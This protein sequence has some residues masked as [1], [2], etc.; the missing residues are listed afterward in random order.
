MQETAADIAGKGIIPPGQEAKVG[1][2]VIHGQQVVKVT[3][4]KDGKTEGK[5]VSF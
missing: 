4:V 2:Y 1:D 5:V 3:S